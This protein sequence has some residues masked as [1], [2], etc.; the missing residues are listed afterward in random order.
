MKAILRQAATLAA[1]AGMASAA[2]ITSAGDWVEMLNASN[3]TAGAGSDLPACM[4]SISGVTTLSI[5]NVAGPWRVTVRSGTGTWDSHVTLYVK[6]TSAGIGSGTITGGDTYTAVSS[7]DTDFF[8][9]SS[10]RSTISVQYK[11][12]GL[13]HHLPPATYLSTLSFTVQ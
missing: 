2:D 8:S 12:M 9:G 3:L 6:R 10:N 1:L 11:L 7:T 13:A 4:Q 5:S